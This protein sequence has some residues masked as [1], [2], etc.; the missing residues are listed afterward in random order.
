MASSV[1]VA[2]ALVKILLNKRR[3]STRVLATELDVNKDTILNHAQEMQSYGLV[4]IKRGRSG[5]IIWAIGDNAA[6]KTY[7][8]NKLLTL[9]DKLNLGLTN[10]DCLKTM[11]K[12]VEDA[13]KDA[14]KILE[15]LES[16]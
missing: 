13:I 14:Q 10:R 11:V 12:T 16:A 5:G 3:C 6:L 2:Y 15:F 7:L 8:Q 9:L 4:E 1:S